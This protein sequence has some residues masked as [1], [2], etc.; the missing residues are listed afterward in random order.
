MI[1]AAL[2]KHQ[3][4]SMSADEARAADPETTGEAAHDAAEMFRKGGAPS[5]PGKKTPSGPC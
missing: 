3:V 1:K 5:K 2:Q 4:D